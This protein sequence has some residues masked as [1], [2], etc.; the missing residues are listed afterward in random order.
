MAS[1]F[2]AS[3]LVA[4]RQ[5]ASSYVLGY[6]ADMPT[7]IPG[8][9]S[10]GISARVLSELRIDGQGAPDA[11]LLAHSW[12]AS[13]AP[14][15]GSRN[16]RDE[17]HCRGPDR[18]DSRR[19]MP[20]LSAVRVRAPH[21]ANSI[22]LMIVSQPLLIESVLNFSWEKRPRTERITRVIDRQD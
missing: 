14:S 3:L 12:P 16:E 15:L 13:S 6:E 20:A 18:R 17:P 4:D 10:L 21:R 7:V 8:T 1:P 22:S 5:D 11:R 2:A 19:C 9:T